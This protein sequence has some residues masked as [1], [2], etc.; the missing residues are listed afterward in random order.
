MQSPHADRRAYLH[1][2]SR[3]P[4][5]VNPIFFGQT[6]VIG[7]LTAATRHQ[8][9]RRNFVF[10][11]GLEGPMAEPLVGERPQR[12]ARERFNAEVRLGYDKNDLSNVTG[13]ARMLADEGFHSA[14]VFHFPVS[15]D[16]E[17]AYALRRALETTGLDK[18]ASIFFYLHTNAD[19]HYHRPDDPVFFR[20]HA[21]MVRAADGIIGVSQAVRDNF[22]KVRVQEGGHELGLDPARSHVVRNGIDPHI[23]VVR[24]KE[25]I[26]AARK[27]LG[28]AAGLD[29]VVSFVGRMDRL[30]GSDYLIKVLE[31]YEASTDP[32]DSGTGFVIATSHILNI[33]QSSRPFKGLMR[34]RRL[35]QEDRLKVVLDISKFTRGDSRFREDVEGMLK[36]YADERGLAAMLEDPLFNRLYGGMTNIP[37][38]TVSDIYLHPS[39]SE[40]FGLAVLEAVFGGAYV[41]STNVG[42][43]PEIIVDDRL[44]RLVEPESD[45]KTFV[46]KLVGA[47]R[48]SVRPA[49]YDR[50]GL[51]GYFSSYT[52]TSMF[53]KFE[54]AVEE[55]IRG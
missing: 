35:I 3:F 8:P 17:Y 4:F 48:D 16:C 19:S 31:H 37:V 51:E 34:M 26:D 46:D 23:Y 25:E 1:F 24:S 50:K 14:M 54:K 28:L 10:L 40:A 32:K 44:G 13:L 49:V 38:Q 18:H 30:K 42:G 12:L 21:D 29:K 6:F 11:R 27:E 55:G 45:K 5:P 7:N 2:G 53:Q 47:V 36:S 52:E 43:I 20:Y 22:V 15:P 9:E 41:I 33:A 39:R